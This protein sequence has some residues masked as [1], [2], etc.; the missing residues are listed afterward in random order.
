VC[1]LLF[2]CIYVTLLQY[3][4]SS[5]DEISIFEYKSEVLPTGIK[6]LS[7]KA[8]DVSVLDQV[9]NQHVTEGWELASYSYM[10]TSFQT[11]GA[12]LITFRK[13]K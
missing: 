1:R 7:Y 6:W 4:I 2:F 11:R 5:K 12:T 13:P 8:S 10:A 3:I 9:I